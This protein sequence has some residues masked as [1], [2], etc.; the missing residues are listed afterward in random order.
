[1]VIETICFDEATEVFTRPWETNVCFYSC[2][3]KQNTTYWLVAIK[4]LKEKWKKF[5]KYHT[6]VSCSLSEYHSYGFMLNVASLY[7][8]STDI[9]WPILPGNVIIRLLW[10]QGSIIG[11]MVERNTWM[12]LCQWLIYRYVIYNHNLCEQ[13]DVGYHCESIIQQLRHNIPIERTNNLQKM[14]ESTKI[15]SSK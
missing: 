5:W 13:G 3:T 12:I 15:A 7:R 10:T 1:M 9:S 2:S 8:P 4:R 6:F 11:E 14:K